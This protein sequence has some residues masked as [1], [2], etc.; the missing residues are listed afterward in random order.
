MKTARSAY[1]F[2]RGIALCG[3]IIWVIFSL[4]KL[5]VLILGNK[6]FISDVKSISSLIH[7]LSFFCYSV[8]FAGWFRMTSKV[9]NSPSTRNKTLMALFAA[10]VTVF[11]SLSMVSAF[12]TDVNFTFSQIVF[13]INGLFA[14]WVFYDIKSNWFGSLKST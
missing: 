6:L 11:G 12:G 13:V 3:A 2:R 4:Y 7:F 1:K 8:F 10:I 9:E 5:S 14:I